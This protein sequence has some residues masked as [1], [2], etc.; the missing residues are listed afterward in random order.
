MPDQQRA[1]VTRPAGFIRR[2][3]ALI[4]DTLLLLAVLFLATLLVLPLTG[5]EGVAPYHPI[6]RTYLLFVAFFYF[7]WQW[8]RGGHTLG[9]RTWHLRVV[10]EDGRPLT[11]WHALLRFMLAIVI[12]FRPWAWPERVCGFSAPFSQARWEDLEASPVPLGGLGGAPRRVS[13]CCVS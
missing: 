11:W 13:K 8:V 5:G 3:A 4:Y 9:M 12:G 2:L 10:Q 1:Y 7:A 6:F